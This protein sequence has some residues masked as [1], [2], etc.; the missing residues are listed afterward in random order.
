MSACY[1]GGEADEPAVEDD[2]D[3]AGDADDTPVPDGPSI[4]GD[5]ITS[6]PV[7]T[8][9][10]TYE[11]T[12]DQERDRFGPSAYQVD[13]RG[14]NWL[15]DGPTSKILVVNDDGEVVDAYYLDGLTAAKFPRLRA[16]TLDPAW[17]WPTRFSIDGDIA[18]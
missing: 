5:R 7:G 11:G 18:H 13:E 14:L 12:G 1:G 17:S 4:Q 16:S 3:S 2:G 8:G 15:A 6:I 9:G 10:L